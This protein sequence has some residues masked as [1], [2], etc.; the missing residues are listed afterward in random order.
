MTR[1][2]R[3]TRNGS[4]ELEERCCLACRVWWGRLGESTHNR[5]RGARETELKLT[6]RVCVCVRLCRIIFVRRVVK[7]WYTRQERE[8]GT[9][10]QA[11]PSSA[12]LRRPARAREVNQ[13]SSHASPSVLS[14]LPTEKQLRELR[15]K[16]RSTIEDIKK[17]TNYYTTKNL[18]EKYDEGPGKVSRSP[19]H[20]PQPRGHRLLLLSDSTPFFLHRVQPGPQP[21]PQDPSSLRRRAFPLPPD[22]RQRAIST[23]SSPAGQGSPSPA[24]RNGAGSSP[25]SPLAPGPLGGQAPVAGTPHPPGSMRGL[26]GQQQQTPF[27][28]ESSPG[29]S[30]PS[31]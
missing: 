10:A 4:R 8:E 23:P 14:L 1:G 13:V 19:P 22:V 26:T 21:P 17:K 3:G 2:G 20:A 16:Q 18:L 7:M 25:S 6:V 12:E 29:L 11:S 15:I 30:T 27:P 31:R 9:F 28:R 24:P 5:V